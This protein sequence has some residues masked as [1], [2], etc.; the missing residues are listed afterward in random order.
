M[1]YDIPEPKTSPNKPKSTK[2]KWYAI[3]IILIVLLSSFAAL[4]I[5]HP[6]NTV[7]G[8]KI[9][10]AAN[11][12]TAGDTYNITLHTNEPFKY[13][14]IHWGDNSESLIKS[15]G[16]KIFA[17]HI[18]N[19]PGIYYIH[20]SINFGNSFYKNNTFIPVYV[21]SL[22]NN[23]TA[24]G[25]IYINNYSRAPSV[26]NSNIF[27]SGTDIN[28]SASYSGEPQNSSYQVIAQTLF[29]YKN[30]SLVKT[31]NLPYKFNP[32]SR[33]YVNKNNSFALKNLSSG[34]YTLKL[35]TYSASL[36]NK[37]IN[38]N[39][40]EY[41]NVTY[42]SGSHTYGNTYNGHEIEYIKYKNYTEAM[43]INNHSIFFAGA[44]IIHYSN[45]NVFSAKGDSFDI[46][47]GSKIR[48]LKN[49]SIELP[50]GGSYVLNNKSHNAKNETILELNKT[51]TINFTSS[52]PVTTLNSTYFNYINTSILYNKGNSISINGS[53]FLIYPHSELLYENNSKIKYSNSTN[54]TIAVSINGAINAGI[55]GDINA[56][57][58]IYRTNYYMDI[59]VYSNGSLYINNNVESMTYSSTSPYNTLNPELAYSKSDLQILMN[60]EQFLVYHNNTSYTPEIASY[61]PSSS[62]GGIS[63]NREDYTF[64]IYNKAFFQNG[65]KVNAWDAAYSIA[66][67]L[68]L[69]NK[70]PQTPG[71][72]LAQYL[73]PGNYYKT[74][75]YTNIANAI[76]VNNSTDNITLHFN[77]PMSR[78]LVFNILSSPGAFIT[79]NS[80]I[81]KYG[82]LTWSEKGFS[83]FKNGTYNQYS[84][85]NVISSGPYEIY[86]SVKNSSVTLI[87]N[88]YF[89]G[90]PGDP[91]PKVNM[92]MITYK[93]ALSEIY[94]NLRLNVTQIAEFPSI[95]APY[96]KQLSDV[97]SYN[98]TINYT[99][100]YNFNANVSI[101]ELNKYSYSNMP[102]NLFSNAT[103]REAFYYAF[104]DNY[105]LTKSRDLW[106]SFV[107]NDGSKY[108]I[109]YDNATKDYNYK[110]NN[111]VIPI[112]VNQIS[113]MK[114]ITAF[115]TNLVHI[116]NGSSY[117]IITENSA[118]MADNEQYG[119]NPMPIYN[120]LINSNMN[121]TQYYTYL[122]STLN[123]THLYNNG[124][125]TYNFNITDRN[126]SIYM[127][128]LEQN[129]T[130]LNEK[131]NST[132]LNN[133]VKDLNKL[134]L[135]INSGSN[136]FM[137]SYNKHI[138]L[139][140]AITEESIVMF[141][142]IN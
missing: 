119:S 121:K 10:S 20:Y 8:A 22:N 51:D 76:T 19:N 6:S 38:V 127:K 92:V 86:S 71:W 114:N 40:T 33:L 67:D 90:R 29:V 65:N 28:L 49:T 78:N 129:I 4:S 122:G 17:S 79:S 100:L 118:F 128:Y 125:S 60:T 56:S 12:I 141:N 1:D 5:F 112:F 89:E 15:S 64:H 111:I 138:K 46:S 34:M 97:N 98:N 93:S 73:L 96:I 32:S 104:G 91:V 7:P 68:L 94:Q 3:I 126:Q 88:P 103:V 117:P 55:T 44:S 82:N 16:D 9:D 102:Y 50:L 21:T 24:S 59:P 142:L 81:A 70:T 115:T 61:L 47:N 84:L 53:K 69:V 120:M 39:V 62:N 106:K 37:Y 107:K 48:V 140:N 11:Y 99:E 110:G 123:Y 132:N 23:K 42:K 105:N 72:L 87:K 27:L 45:S 139:N 13:A 54:V 18:Y 109:K 83:E 131:Y 35:V 74:N 136:K 25:I 2:N 57:N 58:G 75:N 116:I 36:L 135:Y 130:E 133:T 101:K 108:G 85:N 52:V 95:Y 66:A 124:F 63:G 26:P 80:Y 41:N 113:N 31:Y 30:G 77:R 134:H 137:F 43:D 14:E